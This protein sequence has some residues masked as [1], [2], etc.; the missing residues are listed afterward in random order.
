MMRLNE[1]AEA[2]VRNAEFRDF[3]P[4]EARWALVKA[5]KTEG[6]L[7]PYAVKQ[8]RWA[9]REARQIERRFSADLAYQERMTAKGRRY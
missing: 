5:A 1:E 6:D 3:W 7:P 4:I 2:L 8:V 9:L